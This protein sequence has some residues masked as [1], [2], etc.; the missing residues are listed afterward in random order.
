MEPLPEPTAASPRRP[1]RERLRTH[2]TRPIDPASLVAFRVMF[3]ALV[4]VSAVR[5]MANG[6][7]ERFF[8]EPRFFFRYW[9]FE[10]VPVPS[11]GALYA[12]FLALVVTGLCIIVGY[13]H[14]LA[15]AV[16]LVLFTWI[17]LIDVTNYLNHY[18]LMSLLGLLVVALPLGRV[19]VPPFAAR[20]PS[21]TALPAWMLWLVRFQVGVVYV[22]AG[23]AKAGPDWL[24]HGQPLN[25]WLA[26]RQDFP[27]VGP[28]FELGWVSLA[29]SWAG[30]LHDL[31][32]PFALAWRRTRAFAYAALLVFHLTTH[33]LFD[34]GMFPFI[35]SAAATVFFAPDWPRRFVARA[36]PDL[37]AAPWVAPSLGWR[38][39][40]SV[41]VGLWAAWQVAVPLRAH[42]YGGDVLW[43]EQGMRW[44]WRVMVREKNGSVDYRVRV[45]GRKGEQ[46][47]PPRRYLTAHQEREMS[48]QPDLI[49]QLAHHIA[50]DF[51]A[52]GERDV[53]VRVDAYAS[54]N[55]RPPARLIDPTVDLT[56]VDD[57]IAQAAWIT[58]APSSPPPRLEPAALPVGA[59]SVR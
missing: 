24:E 51:R 12:M 57:G 4:V 19:G 29:L 15:A 35:M 25:L 48:G 39:V 52:R 7:V 22:F 14:R 43:H 40:T 17:E 23:L 53:E 5:F 49:L 44:S 38:R 33:L 2:A 42:A 34:I 30:F 28:L 54:L 18:Y 16:N 6:W 37:M 45:A 13:R 58:P 27:L 46:H 32:V 47:V 10:W 36:R 8:G 55:G 56:T 41:V 59:R 3:G 20:A 50:A 31:L 21:L 9:G 1:W 26:A 11:V